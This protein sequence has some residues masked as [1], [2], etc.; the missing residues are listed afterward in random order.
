MSSGELVISSGG[1]RR[2]DPRRRFFGGACDESDAEEAA[3]LLNEGALNALIVGD[4]KVRARLPGCTCGAVTVVWSGTWGN[5]VLLGTAGLCCGRRG[6]IG[7]R[8]T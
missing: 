3:S 4:L 2:V 6:A 8:G 1:G 5:F 7:V